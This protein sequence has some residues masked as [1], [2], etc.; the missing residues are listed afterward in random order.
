MARIDWI[1]TRLLNWA[2]WKLTRGAGV[3]G[4]AAVDLTDPTPG[5]R[6]A[7]AEAPIPTND[8]EASEIDDLM[9]R[10]QVCHGDLHRTVVEWYIANVPLRKKLKRLCCSESTLHA[11]IDKAHRLLAGWINDRADARRV[12]RARVEAMRAGARP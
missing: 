10:M 9:R 8:V 3:L 6:E 1:E 5:V 11:R 4:Y 2:R 7:Y 12:E